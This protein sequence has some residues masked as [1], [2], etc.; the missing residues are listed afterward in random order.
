MERGATA[1]AEWVRLEVSD[2]GA[3]MNDAALARLFEPFFTT[4]G[5]EKGTG[6]GLYTTS[7]LVR[8]A[9]GTIHATTEP[10]VGTHFVVEFPVEGVSGAAATSL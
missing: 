10:G 9:G 8:Q 4:K 1:S 5:D 6:L 7:L 3:G 2:T